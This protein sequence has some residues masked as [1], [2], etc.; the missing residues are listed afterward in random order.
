M[1]KLFL[2]IIISIFISSCSN[3]QNQINARLVGAPCEGCEAIFEYGD[4]ILSPVDTLP[5]FQRSDMKL[6]V[7]GTVYKTDG[8]TPAKDV[9]VYAYHTNSKGIYAADKNASGWGRRHGYNRGWVK[10][11]ANGYYAFYTIKPA[12]YPNANIPAHIHFTV[13]EP[14]GKYY[15]IDDCTFEGDKFLTERETNPQSPRGGSSGLLHLK[16]ERSL[17]VGTR[18][19]ILG[20][21][22]PGYE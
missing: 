7:E 16:E 11:D 13:L 3:P 6:K 5:D 1:K 2:V 20:R 9:I 12:S 8:K 22:V 15:Y 21:N 10:T 19:I 4:K 18:N 14:D 17:L